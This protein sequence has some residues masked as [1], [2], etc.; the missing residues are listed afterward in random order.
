[1]PSALVLVHV[2]GATIVWVLA[3]GALLASRDTV[4]AVPQQ[5]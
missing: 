1:L 2:A 4:P 5:D 3:V